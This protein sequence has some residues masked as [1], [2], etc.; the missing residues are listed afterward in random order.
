[1]WAGIKQQR[2]HEGNMKRTQRERGGS[3]SGTR[4]A[5][6]VIS[7][8]RGILRNCNFS[9]DSMEAIIIGRAAFLAPGISIDPD[10]SAL[11]N[12]FNLSIFVC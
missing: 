6:E 9:L 12:I 10:R 2:E 8:R 3:I 1:M 4:R 11:P 5:L 7:K